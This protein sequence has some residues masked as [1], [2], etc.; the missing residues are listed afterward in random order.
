MQNGHDGELQT[1]SACNSSYGSIQEE[2]IE[3]IKPQKSYK[4]RLFDV[5]RSTYSLGIASFG[6]PQ[7]HIA[8]FH[9]IFVV[10]K[11]W[12]SEDQFTGLFAMSSSLPGSASNHVRYLTPI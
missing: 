5:I 4:Q 7:A 1:V 10:E 2:T 11:E 6:G 9:R 8:N 12:V 3:Y